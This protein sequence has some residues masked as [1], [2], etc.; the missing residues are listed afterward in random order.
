MT[1]FRRSESPRLC[2]RNFTTDVFYCFGIHPPFTQR[3]PP[4]DTN[5][6]GI[7]Q[8]PNVGA[9]VPEV[10]VPLDDEDAGVIDT[11]PGI[12]PPFTHV[13]PPML[14]KGSGMVQP[15]F[16]V[17]EDVTTTVVEVVDVEDVDDDDVDVVGALIPAGI[18]PPL[19]Q[20]PPP[21]AMN[22]SGVEQVLGDDVD[23]GSGSVTGSEDVEALAVLSMPAG[24]HPPFTHAPPPIA[25][26][27]SGVTQPLVAAGAEVGIEPGV[28]NATP[29]VRSCTRKTS[30]RAMVAL[31]P[32]GSV[33]SVFSQFDV[34]S[35][36]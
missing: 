15:A 6:S 16:D 2:K 33:P 25:M 17:V 20:L 18:H 28:P 9:G 7:V 19:T 36:H 21:I 35:T 22:G 8:P 5:G 11:W 29:V 4:I 12:Q 32:A 27:G 14:T 34:K 30:W 31:S 23:G 26:K 13:P 10:D 1:V 3:P 24:I